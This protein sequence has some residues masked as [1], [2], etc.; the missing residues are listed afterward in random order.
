MLKHYPSVWGT[1]SAC[2]ILQSFMSLRNRTL[3]KESIKPAK[4][5]KDICPH[6][7][8]Q[9]GQ[10]W[11]PNHKHSTKILPFFAA[12]TMSL[13]CVL[14]IVIL[15]DQLSAHAWLPGVVFAK[16]VGKIK[17]CALWHQCYYYGHLRFY[18]FALLLLL[19]SICEANDR[20]CFKQYR[21]LL[22][23]SQHRTCI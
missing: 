11:C 18:L 16:H 1:A 10:N 14:N 23:E 2:H 13:C 5:L 9:I 17:H 7:G 6:A 20:R 21:T 3:R 12:S 4:T 8:R 15:C 22:L 19:L